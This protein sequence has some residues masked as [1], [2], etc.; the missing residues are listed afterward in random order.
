MS[1]GLLLIALNSH[2]NSF[3]FGNT[4]FWWVV[5]VFVLLLFYI[6]WRSTFL[7][8][9][10]WTIK[11]LLTYT[12]LQVI[13][14][15]FIAETYWDWK[16]L[17]SNS[18]TLMLPMATV[19]AYNPLNIQ[20]LLNRYIYIAAPLFLILQFYFGKDEYG[21]YLAPFAFLSLFIPVISKR[22]VI[23][24]ISIS[25]FVIISDL[26][27]R[28]NVIKFVLPVVFSMLHNFK[29][30]SSTDRL[31]V[32]RYILLIIPFIFFYLGISGTFNVFN[33]TGNSKLEIVEKKR[34][35]N[36]QL[37]EDNLL[38]DTRTFLYVEV[39]QSTN[40]FDS[41][42]FG[43]SP[44][45]GNISDHF[46]ELD[47]NNRNERNANEVGI[48]N[49]FNWMGIIGVALVFIVYLQATKLAIYDSNNLFSKILGL[50]VSFRWVYFWVE[51]MTVFH[52]QD[53]YLWFMIG[54]C[55][56]EKFR[57]MTDNEVKV[58]VNSIFK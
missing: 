36:G 58:W 20:Y 28:S 32:I 9:Q 54:L 8:S 19:V 31:K 40:K 26:G 5:K 23:I 12:L 37:V 16:N 29:S 3:E 14:G 41:W 49:Y 45:R 46:G 2:G 13:R 51:E 27:A 1:F 4:F 48:L 44:A 55:Y 10:Y 6:F 39:L 21:F 7:N 30:F 47:L 33:P 34:D 15:V 22:W 56:S 35:A 53:V 24:I 17:F 57:K 18:L 25:F 42:I 43:R 52:I 38:S 11:I 50:F